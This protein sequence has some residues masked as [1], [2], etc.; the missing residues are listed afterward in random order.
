MFQF[1]LELTKKKT[2]KDLEKK[3]ELRMSYRLPKLRAKKFFQ[4]MKEKN[5]NA[6]ICNRINHYLNCQLVTYSTQDKCSIL[7][8]IN[9]VV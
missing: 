4:L 9:V 3:N 7:L 1:K 2:E 5:S 6:L 8:E